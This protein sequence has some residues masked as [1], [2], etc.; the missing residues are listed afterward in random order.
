MKKTNLRRHNL[1]ALPVL[2]EIL[3]HGNLTKAAKALGLTQPALSNIL[4]QLR[5]D[6]DDPLI[7]RQGQK[8]QL[9]P[10]AIELMEPLE[11]AM[12]SLESLLS[13]ADFDPAGSD[14]AFRIATTDFIITRLGAPLASLIAEQAPGISI[15]MQ[16]AQL[17]SVQALMVGDLDM[18]ISPT[19]LL[20]SGVASQTES[21]SVHSEIIL[22][23]PMV[24]LAHAGDAEFAA[25]L[26]LEAYLARPH[27]G[28]IFGNSGSSSM[29]QVYMRR[30]GLRQNEK[31]LVASYSAL[32]PI[33][34]QTGFLALVPLSMAQAAAD[35]YP[36]QFAPPPFAPVEMDWSMIWHRRQDSRPDL[37]WLKASVKRLAAE[38][39][40]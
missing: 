31:I 12:Q 9:T 4:K 14:R 25:G 27:A 29:E 18:I 36:V 33:V 21:E 7:A 35:R 26:T 6:F 37:Q 5:H 17:F 39:S 15:Q 23:E 3:K 32:A 16:A 13:A 38:E 22:T 1:N 10:K 19:I 24:C 8:M 30:L 20:T 34:A 28:Y 40:K 11:Q 2:R